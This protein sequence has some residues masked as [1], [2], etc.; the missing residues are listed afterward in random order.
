MP[1][2]IDLSEVIQ[3]A[4]DDVHVDET[5]ESSPAE[6][7]QPEVETGAE[8]EAQPEVQTDEVAAEQAPAEDSQNPLD[9][10]SPQFAMDKKLGIPSHT[11]GRENRIP[12]SRVKKIVE[13]AEK[14]AI[15]PLQKQLAELTPKIQEYEQRLTQVAEFEQ[16]MANDPGRFLD[17]LSTLPAYSQFF[18]L[19]E[20]FVTSQSQGV[21][22]A[23]EQVAQDIM[24]NDPMPEPDD[25]DGTGYTMEGLKKL[26]E[27]NSRVVESRVTKQVE[28]QYKPIKDRFE[29]ERTLQEL[30][31]KVQKQMEEAYKWP[32]FAEN[33]AEII[34]VLERYPTATLEQAYQHVVVPKLVADE[35]RL[36]NDIRQQVLGELKKAPPVSTGVPVSGTKPRPASASGPRSLEEVIKE[37]MEE[38]GLR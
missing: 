29:A 11:N 2:P 7:T 5:L 10:N 28:S 9:P 19:V 21:Q 33:E 37:Q 30:T 38:K 15:E 32:K 4:V 23:P 25:E 1:T 18:Q 22:P 36:R 16:V 17:M 35:Q 8:V 26:L 13:G 27:W 20:Q 34:Q 31:P 24:A 3:D 6:E 14:R 12:Y